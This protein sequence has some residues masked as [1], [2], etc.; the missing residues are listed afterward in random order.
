MRDLEGKLYRLW[1]VS[2]AMFVGM[3]GRDLFGK[4]WF[5]WVINDLLLITSVALGTISIRAGLK[6]TKKGKKDHV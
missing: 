2:L 3:L 4:G 1:L 6:G 5:D